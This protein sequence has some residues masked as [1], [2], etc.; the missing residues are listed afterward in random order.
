MAYVPPHMRRRDQ[1]RNFLSSLAES[2]QLAQIALCPT[3]VPLWTSLIKSSLKE[4]AAALPWYHELDGYVLI[5]REQ[6]EISMTE[7]GQPTPL[8]ERAIDAKRS[9]L[10]SVLEAHT[11]DYYDKFP[12]DPVYDP[13]PDYE[14]SSEDCPE[15]SYEDE[16]RSD[17]D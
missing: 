14:S 15:E 6:G 16:Y 8:V 5:R 9:S 4:S 7:L 11:T 3:A 13:E 17:E 12:G 2:S 1:R 10:V